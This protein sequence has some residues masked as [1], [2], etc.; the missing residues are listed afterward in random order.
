ME[1]MQE[2]KACGFDY[3]NNVAPENYNDIRYGN[4]HVPKPTNSAA[5]VVHPEE[6]MRAVNEGK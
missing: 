2:D 3:P 4:R 6:V 5:K 1:K